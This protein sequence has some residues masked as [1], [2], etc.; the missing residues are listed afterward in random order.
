M[1]AVIQR[2]KNASVKIE[3]KTTASINKGLLVL[4]AISESDD[5]KTAEWLANKIARLRVF[6]DENGKMNLSA[7]DVGGEILFV[8]NFTIYGDVSKG[9]R[10]NYMKSAPAEFSK[11]FYEKFVEY[12]RNKYPVKT[13]SGVFGAMMDVSLVNDGP[14]T[15]VIE[16]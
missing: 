2:V 3:G 9:F 12:F 16:K 5:E 6:P 7:L 10:P 1:K 15:I 8:S 14:V 13:E 11:P 4:L